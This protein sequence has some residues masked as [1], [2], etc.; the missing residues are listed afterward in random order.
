MVFNLY[1]NK[2]PNILNANMLIKERQCKYNQLPKISKKRDKQTKYKK[3][4]LSILK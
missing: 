3:Y 2:I 1:V 4:Y